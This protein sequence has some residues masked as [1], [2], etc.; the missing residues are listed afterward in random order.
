[1]MTLG[2]NLHILVSVLCILVLSP[3]FMGIVTTSSS[4]T[5]P[6]TIINVQTISS[7]K[8]MK[9]LNTDLVADEFIQISL[10]NN[11]SKT[12]HI[13]EHFI[14]QSGIREIWVN[15]TQ[16][17]SP[18]AV[19]TPSLVY[20]LGFHALSGPFP[21][22]YPWDG[23]TFL[24][25]G[26]NG[27]HIVEY[28]CDDNFDTYYICQWFTSWK[29]PGVDFKHVHIPA[30]DITDWLNGVK[31]RADIIGLIFAILG[32]TASI[33]GGVASVLGC[34][35]AGVPAIIG[36]IASILGAIIEYILGVTEYNWIRDVVQTWYGDGFTWFGTVHKF[37]SVDR[38]Y[39]PFWNKAITVR[40]WY[41]H[42]QWQQRWGAHRDS[43]QSYSVSWWDHDEWKTGG[44]QTYDQGK[45]WH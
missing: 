14:N 27:T 29:L 33:I 28:T 7:K 16:T 32:G 20:P 18:M 15:M 40:Y 31:S 12:V 37:L 38:W 43:P 6:A 10:W 11:G 1:M 45:S 42:A 4:V 5:V 2:K 41:V 9:V 30:Q 26:N 34:P 44:P 22:K 39:D 19:T 3:Q 23:L 35:E 25:K 13:S 21:G 24:P 36:G 8:Y 17:I